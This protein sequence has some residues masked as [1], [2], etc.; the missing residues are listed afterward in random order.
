[1]G[2]YDQY[3]QNTMEGN[4]FA[5]ELPFRNRQMADDEKAAA[6]AQSNFMLQNGQ[7]QSQ[8]GFENQGVLRTRNLEDQAREAASSGD[9]TAIKYLQSMDQEQNGPEG[10]MTGPGGAPM[11][12]RPGETPITSGMSSGVSPAGSAAQSSG[13]QP[14]MTLERLAKSVVKQNP[15][16]ANNPAAFFQAMDKLKP[17]LV[18]ND[19]QRLEQMKFQQQK[20][21]QTQKDT[22]SME[23]V[24]ARPAS[25]GS[26]GGIEGQIIHNAMLPA[27]QG[28]EGLSFEQAIEK[29][30]AY[31]RAQS[32]EAGDVAAAK[33]EGKNRGDKEQ[34]AMGAKDVLNN[35]SKLTE[36]SKTTP[37]G[38]LESGV[39]SLA[40]LANVP[41]EGSKA[42]GKFD[43]DIN[44]L[45][46]ATV[47]TLKGT[48]RVMQAEISNIQNA[49]PKA[50]DSN[51]VKQAKIKSHMDYYKSRMKELGYDPETGKPASSEEKQTDTGQSDP[52]GLF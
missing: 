31:K 41:T 8:Q 10:T 43:A 40:N 23:R 27:E 4:K 26:G 11:K 22:A 14:Q 52:L 17:M 35:Y 30:K 15:Q 2:Y 32:G 13:G 19:Q 3:N 50:T 36:D 12:L 34:I 38:A 29:A 51:E 37:S 44:N 24:K 47:R 33:Q 25:G 1:M 46:L 45:F 20:E 7:K 42:Q 6:L 16:L 21:L 18:G 39:A 49:A 5:R 48:G 28:G 9:L